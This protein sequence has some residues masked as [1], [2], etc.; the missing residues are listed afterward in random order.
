MPRRPPGSTG[1]S[2]EED[3]DDLSTDNAS[4]EEEEIKEEVVIKVRKSARN[5]QESKEHRRAARPVAKTKTAWDQSPQQ[6]KTALKEK[7]IAELQLPEN[8]ITQDAAMKKKESQQRAQWRNPW[9]CSKLTLGSLVAAAGLMLCIW[10][11][12]TTRQLDPKGA[13]M[14]YM[15]SAFVRFP[16]FD[17]EHTRFATKYSLHLYREMGVD[18]EDARVWQYYRYKEGNAR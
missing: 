17:T 18:D 8:D 7:E 11:S 14:S 6:R 13:A 16:D 4:H 3:Q 9:A 15:A 5:V 10:Q 2:S 12:F 1:S